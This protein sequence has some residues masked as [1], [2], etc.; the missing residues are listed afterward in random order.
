M[1]AKHVFVKL[2]PSLHQLQLAYCMYHFDVEI[3]LRKETHSFGIIHHKRIVLTLDFTCMK[4]KSIDG[5]HDKQLISKV[6]GTHFI[7]Y[8]RETM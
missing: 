5:P 4:N 3:Q 2:E 8:I 1:L 6:E 7:F